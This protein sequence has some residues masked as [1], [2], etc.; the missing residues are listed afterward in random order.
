MPAPQICYGRA[1][2]HETAYGHND[3]CVGYASQ[4]RTPRPREWG[5]ARKILW[6]GFASRRLNLPLFYIVSKRI[7]HRPAVRN[8]S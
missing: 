1:A 3:T 4:R 8:L 7:Q 6:S 5:E 2:G